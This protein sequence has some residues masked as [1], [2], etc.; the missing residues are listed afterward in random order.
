[1]RCLVL[2]SVLGTTGCSGIF[3]GF[4]FFGGSSDRIHVEADDND[5][6]QPG[7]KVS[8]EVYPR[9]GQPRP[10]LFGSNGAAGLHSAAGSGGDVTRGEGAEVEGV[11]PRDAR[12][13]GWATPGSLVVDLEYSVGIG[14]DDDEFL[15]APEFVDY[16]GTRFSAPQ[17]LKYDYDLHL[18]SISARGG[19]RFF[20]VLAVEVLVGASSSVLDLGVRGSGERST[21]TGAAI[22]INVGTRG[23]IT[24]HPV[25]DFYGQWALHILGSPGKSRR[26][27]VFIRAAEVGANLHLTSYVSLFGG[28]RWL[29]Y[30]EDIDRASDLDVDLSG[31]SFGLLFRF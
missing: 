20:D 11:E 5:V 25:I 8:L 13:S 6:I 14:G 7:V 24:P 30:E 9:T 22:G 19:P 4:N 31:P 2:A 27:T 29:K 18:G 10:G 1:L 28:W 21:D 26:N 17:R 23:T 3:T 15:S 16:A 12:R